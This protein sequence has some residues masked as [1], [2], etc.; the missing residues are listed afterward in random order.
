MQQKQMKG[1][2]ISRDGDFYRAATVD[3]EK[4]A[5]G[6]YQANYDSDNGGAL[7]KVMPHNTDG[8]VRLPDDVSGRVLAEIDMFHARRAE[9]TKRGL[10]HKRGV[11]LYGPPGG[12]KTS[13][14]NLLVELFVDKMGGIALHSSDNPWV[15]AEC[16]KSLRKVEADRRVLCIIEDIDEMYHAGGGHHVEN[17]LSLLD[18]EDQAD[19]V[20]YV[21]TTNFIER[22]D[23]RLVGRPSR[24]DVIEEVGMPSAECRAAYLAHKEPGMPVSE[25]AAYVEA[26]AGFS[27]AHLRELIVLTQCFGQPLERAVKRLAAMAEIPAYGVERRNMASLEKARR[28]P[29]PVAMAGEANSAAS[30]LGAFR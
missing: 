9:F 14:V 6:V 20:V 12:G 11:L 29:S 3:V 1:W 19:G 22:L 8:L 2:N 10:L 17:L 21:A 30:A 5:A 4:I 7:F 26:T 13:T 23:R 24:F 16:L 18:G 28:I 27:L 15:T 25:V